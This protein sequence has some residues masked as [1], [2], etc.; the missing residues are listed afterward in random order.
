VTDYL[1]RLYSDSEGT[2]YRIKVFVL[3]IGIERQPGGE[4]CLLSKFDYADAAGLYDAATELWN[5]GA[6]FRLLRQY[7]IY[8]TN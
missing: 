1:A 3:T 6:L 2:R 5:Y 4:N 8:R 7:P